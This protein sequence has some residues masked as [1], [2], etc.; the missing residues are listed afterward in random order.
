MGIFHKIL[1]L[2]EY[3]KNP[4]FVGCVKLVREIVDLGNPPIIIFVN[5]SSL[6]IDIF[7]AI[8]EII[9]V[10]RVI[11]RVDGN[12]CGIFSGFFVELDGYST[13]L[14]DLISLENMSNKLSISI[15]LNAR[16][17]NAGYH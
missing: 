16:E 12:V 6:F 14:G 3:G 8:D 11:P 2:G 5:N 4:L 13:Y 10:L 7:K 17:V 1:I 9:C 15:L